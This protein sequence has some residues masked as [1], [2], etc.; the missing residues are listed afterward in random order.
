MHIST[1][2]GNSSY[3]YCRGCCYFHG[4]PTASLFDR[5]QKREPSVGRVSQGVQAG[6]RG[7]LPF[8]A[9]TAPRI[10][11]RADVLCNLLA[12]FTKERTPSWQEAAP[13]LPSNLEL[14]SPVSEESC[15]PGLSSPDLLYP[16][17]RFPHLEAQNSAE[18]RIIIQHH[19]RMILPH[20]LEWLSGFW[21]Q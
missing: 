10:P 4:H 1:C 18:S 11:E 5:E 7:V 17:S 21:H 14:L 6:M 9:G 16:S 12:H 2:S 13:R 3:S 20:Q 8:H 15:L 19:L